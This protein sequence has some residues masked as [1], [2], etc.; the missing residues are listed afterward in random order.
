MALD[1]ITKFNQ[2]SKPGPF[3]KVFSP[4][5][6]ILVD[7][8][9][10]ISISDT[11]LNAD[12]ISESTSG[13]GVTIDS[14]L[15]KDGNVTAV[16]ADAGAT[17]GP[18]ITL[19]RNS[20]SPA[21][22]DVIGMVTFD[23]EDSVSNQEE[24]ARIQAVITDPTT[25]TEDGLLQIYTKYDGA[26][27]VLP[28]VQV[29]ETSLSATR[30]VEGAEGMALQLNQISTTPAANDAVGMVKFVGMDNDTP[31]ATNEYAQ[32]SGS[33][34]SAVAGAE[35]GSIQLKVAVGGT[36]TEIAEINENGLV[37]S[38][39]GAVATP[40]IAIGEANTGFYYLSDTQTG[41]ARDG[42]LN[43]TFDTDGVKSDMFGLR[44]NY[45]TTPVGTVTI[46]EYGD[47]RDITTTLTLAN[48]IVGALNGDVDLAI[49]NIVYAFPAYQHI[50][51]A[52]SFYNIVLTAAGTAVAADVGLGSVIA[53][54]AV[55]ALNGDP[56]FEDR[57]TGQTINTAAGGGA[58]VSA[59][60]AATAGVLTGIALNGTGAVKN[61]FLNAAGNWNADNTGNLTASGTIVIKWTVMI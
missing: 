18:E 15:L 3:F 41:F 61:V 53:S 47:G 27:S 37:V 52:Y 59:L 30:T 14:V 46:K 9:N 6:N 38:A 35:D 4:W 60:T 26:M 13:S 11:E 7:R 42:V 40:C 49:G 12:T 31:Q 24:Y 39:H 19:H 25:T 44:A 57:I 51:L 50:E 55:T 33:I 5:Y 43:T 22:L 2:F 23:G 21:A 54:G 10:A 17:G 56:T 20:A 36:V 28:Q 45:G 48:F 8:I 29:S 34:E 16:S 32:I 58:A 1:K